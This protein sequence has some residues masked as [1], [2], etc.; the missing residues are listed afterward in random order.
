MAIKFKKHG[1]K[2]L[3]AGF[4]SWNISII[5]T[6]TQQGLINWK[7]FRPFVPGGRTVDALLHC[8]MR[9]WTLFPIVLCRDQFG[10]RYVRHDRK[11]FTDIY[12]CSQ[13]GGIDERY[14]VE[15]PDNSK[16]SIIDHFVEGLASSCNPQHLVGKAWLLIPN[17]V[18]IDDKHLDE[19]LDAVG[20]WG[21]KEAA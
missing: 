11:A 9:G 20:A 15:Q 16:L 10:K 1:I 7:T 2:T 14:M 5:H 21:E 8:P 4:R 18:D 6:P 3:Q 19:L 13:L 17:I 12:S